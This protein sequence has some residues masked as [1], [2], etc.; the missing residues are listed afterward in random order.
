[1]NLVMSEIIDERIEN[2]KSA[3]NL[4]ISVIT[5]FIQKILFHAWSLTAEKAYESTNLAT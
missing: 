5:P 4:Y 1:M 2:I 3:G